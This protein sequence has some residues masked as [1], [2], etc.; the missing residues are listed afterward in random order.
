M[1]E[2]SLMTGG[3]WAKLIVG[4][5]LIGL[6]ALFGLYRLLTMVRGGA[7]WL[8]WKRHESS[9]GKV[10]R[11][12]RCKGVCEASDVNCQWCG[13]RFESVFVQRNDVLDVLFEQPLTRSAPQA[14]PPTGQ[15]QARPAPQAPPPLE[16]VVIRGSDGLRCG[17]CGDVVKES[18]VRCP[19]CKSKFSDFSVGRVRT[20]TKK[21]PAKQTKDRRTK[22]SPRDD[23]RVRPRLRWQV[24]NR[25]GHKCL[26]CGRSPKDHGVVLHVDHR[27]PSS[28]GGK[29]E[30][31]N[32]LT[33][34]KECNLGK[35]DLIPSEFRET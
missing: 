1:T 26:D 35:G 6:L 4:L 13:V 11:C 31:A 7:R 28:K 8:T 2:V 27:I 10:W 30:L 16:S 34:C 20:Q 33:T 23:P 18:D 19:S 22:P 29:T 9:E 25:D 3:D 17:K 32:L 12:S 5:S 14:P 24:L 21:R 15:A